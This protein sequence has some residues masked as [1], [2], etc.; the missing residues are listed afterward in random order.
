MMHMAFLNQRNV[1][2]LHE[3]FTIYFTWYLHEKKMDFTHEF[4]MHQKG[5]E[6][7]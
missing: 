2:V 7:S 1:F 4:Y 5:M 6:N 3:K